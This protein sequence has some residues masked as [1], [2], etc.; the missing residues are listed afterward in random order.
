LRV[1][2]EQRPRDTEA[3]RLLD[4]IIAEHTLPVTDEPPRKGSVLPRP[5]RPVD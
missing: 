2:V 1:A 3:R 5:V 4:A